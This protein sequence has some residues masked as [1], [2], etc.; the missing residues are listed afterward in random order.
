MPS[1]LAHQMK[2]CVYRSVAFLQRVCKVC[3]ERISEA[4][5]LVRGSE[6]QPSIP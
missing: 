3:E 4:V 2:V 1:V 6:V 5:S